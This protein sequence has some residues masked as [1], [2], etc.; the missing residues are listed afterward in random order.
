MDGH[1]FF[2]EPEV[3]I[4]KM[5]IFFAFAEIPYVFSMEWAFFHEIILLSVIVVLH[6][7][8]SLFFVMWYSISRGMF[9]YLANLT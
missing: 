4:N 1:V 2:C 8:K 9:S 3:L 5:N 7:A 6:H